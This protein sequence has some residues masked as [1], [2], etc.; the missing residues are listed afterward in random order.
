MKVCLDLSLVIMMLMYLGLVALKQGK[1]FIGIELNS[2][3]IKIAE[4]RLK[5]YLTQIKLEV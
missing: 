4:K 3:Y 1:K 2:E 5:P